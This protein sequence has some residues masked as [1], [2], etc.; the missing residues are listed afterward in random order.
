MTIED[1]VTDFRST[2]VNHDVN[3]GWFGDAYLFLNDEDRKNGTHRWCGANCT[4]HELKL[5]NTASETQKVYAAVHT[6]DERGYS[7]DDCVIEW[8][9]YYFDLP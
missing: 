8:T 9:Y 7:Y 1:Y 2:S 5:T 4:K 3:D 6:W